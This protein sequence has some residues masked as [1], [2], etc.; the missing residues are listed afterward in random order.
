MCPVKPDPKRMRC[1]LT[2]EQLRESAHDLREKEAKEQ[3]AREE[4]YICMLR[5]LSVLKNL[6]EEFKE[7]KEKMKTEPHFI[8]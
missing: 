7:E 2:I 1:Y 8:K 3:E 4:R 6:N 5:G